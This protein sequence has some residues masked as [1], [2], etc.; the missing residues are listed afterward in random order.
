MVDSGDVEEQT[1]EDKKE[2]RKSPPVWVTYKDT[3]RIAESEKILAHHLSSE[4]AKQK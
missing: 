3:K 1:N 4:K 2:Y